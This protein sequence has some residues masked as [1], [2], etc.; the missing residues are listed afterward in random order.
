VDPPDASEDDKATLLKM[1][2]NILQVRTVRLELE[3]EIAKYYSYYLGNSLHDEH[4]PINDHFDYTWDPRQP[5]RANVTIP[6]LRRAVNVDIE[7]DGIR[8]TFE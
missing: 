6:F 1:L 3:D 7:I 4:N 2:N 8:L 5:G